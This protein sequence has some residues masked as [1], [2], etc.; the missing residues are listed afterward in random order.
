MIAF[1]TTFL[2]LMIYPGAKHEIENAKERVE[3]LISDIHSNGEKIIIPTPA[4]SE[5]LVRSGNARNDIIQTITRSPKFKLAEFDVRSA[6]ELSL[7]S[8]AA[9]TSKDKKA[10][11]SG[12]WVKVKFDRQIVAIAKTFGARVI[13]SEDGDLLAIAKREGLNA[14]SVCDIKIPTSDQGHFWK[15]ASK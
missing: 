2:A 14:L 8:D 7:M 13:Y 6:L 9:F 1:D 12:T 4:F 5:L 11:A 15:G 10:G 3:F